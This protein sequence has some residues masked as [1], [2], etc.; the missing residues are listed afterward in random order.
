MQVVY[1]PKFCISIVFNFSW[2]AVIPS[3]MKTKV[4]QKLGGGGGGGQARCTMRDVQMEN[5]LNTVGK[6]ASRF[7]QK[8]FERVG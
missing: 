4:M 8:Q 2:M 6:R 7:C 3:K 5:G 1:P